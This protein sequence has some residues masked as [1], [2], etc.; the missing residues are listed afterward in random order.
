MSGLV[1][2]DKAVEIFRAAVVDV[3]VQRAHRR[4]IPCAQIEMLADIAANQFRAALCEGVPT[5][6]KLVHGGTQDEHEG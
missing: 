1:E 4:E 2:I 3:Q 5:S 6:S